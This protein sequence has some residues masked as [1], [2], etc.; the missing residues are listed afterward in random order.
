MLSFLCM[1]GYV[2][3]PVEGEM[4]LKCVQE[5]CQRCNDIHSLLKNMDSSQEDMQ[6]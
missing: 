2:G 4:L 1:Y 5:C 6:T 3:V